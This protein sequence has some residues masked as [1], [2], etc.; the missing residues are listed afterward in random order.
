MIALRRLLGGVGD[1][2]LDS[3]TG[4]GARF[5]LRERAGALTAV[6]A[7]LVTTF[8][9]TTVSASAFAGAALEERLGGIV[10]ERIV[11]VCS[12][13]VRDDDDGNY[14]WPMH[15]E[16]SSNVVVNPSY[17][18]EG[19]EMMVDGGQEGRVQVPAPATLGWVEPF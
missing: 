15:S 5:L 4:E 7:A 9:V 18:V 8:L 14:V 19:R 17:A 6:A 16:D 2:V 11:L 3:G 10:D 1:G 12:D 13:A